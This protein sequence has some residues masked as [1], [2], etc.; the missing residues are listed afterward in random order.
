MTDLTKIAIVVG[1]VSALSACGGAASNES[2]AKTANASAA[3]VATGNA[4]KQGG[5][6]NI[7]NAELAALQKQG[8]T[9]IDIRLPEEWQQTGVVEG[10]QLLTFFNANGSVNPK[11][12]NQATAMAPEGG[13]VALICR[14]G[15]RTRAAADMLVKAGVY[16]RVFN[17]TNGI[18]GWMGEGKPVVAA[19]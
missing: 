8:V 1:L 12:I 2:V 5:V 9:L 19:K 14:T 11:F 15:N 18:T 17:V 7:S 3:T 10:S 16:Q 6:Q 4:M 13:E